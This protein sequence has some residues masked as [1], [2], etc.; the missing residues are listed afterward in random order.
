MTASSPTIEISEKE[1]KWTIKTSTL[2]KTTSYTFSLGEEYDETMGE[3]VI[4]V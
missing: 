3:R 1:E 4:K 2:L